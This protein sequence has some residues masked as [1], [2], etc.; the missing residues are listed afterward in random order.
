MSGGP[1]LDLTALHELGPART[2]YNESR[3]ELGVATAAVRQFLID[4]EGIVLALEG[5]A[6][7]VACRIGQNIF[8]VR[9]S[10]TEFGP[11]LFRIGEVERDT[12]VLGGVESDD[13]SVGVCAS[14]VSL[15][16]ADWDEAALA[17]ESARAANG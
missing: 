13:S 2:A 9:R 15:V 6:D 17:T 4:N 8:T 14:I 11:G 16:I 3:H 1:E 10:R 5:R 12:V 7:T